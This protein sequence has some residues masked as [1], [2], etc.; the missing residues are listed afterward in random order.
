MVMTE[1]FFYDLEANGKKR[2]DGAMMNTSKN[3][4]LSLRISCSSA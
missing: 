3:P 2:V 4:Q 1:S